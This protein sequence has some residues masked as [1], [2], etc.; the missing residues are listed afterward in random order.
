MLRINDSLSIDPDD[1]EWQ[2]IR[3]QGAGGQHVNKVS[4]AVHLRFDIK[5]SSLPHS[6]KER[7]LAYNDRRITK[8]GV[9]VIKAQQHRRQERNHEDALDRLAEIVREATVV[10]PVRKP[11]RPSRSSVR[12]R[13]EKKN[14]H[15]RLKAGRGR[16]DFDD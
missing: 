6:V 4:S 11:T 5:A 7:L 16:L 1:I 9:I 2:A 8:E 15:S 3:A 10:R 12:K 13:L 14:R